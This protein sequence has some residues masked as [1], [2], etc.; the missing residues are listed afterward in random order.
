MNPSSDVNVN[1]CWNRIGVRGDRS[2]ERLAAHT[3]C[4]HCDKYPVAAGEVMQRALPPGYVKESTARYAEAVDTS[5]PLDCSA[6][7]FRIGQEW[8]AI[9]TACVVMVAESATPHRIPH[10][11][12][13]ELL[14]LVNIHGALYPCISLGPMLG[15]D[16]AVAEPAPATASSGRF[17]HM[18]VLRM[19]AQEYAVPVQEVRGIVRYHR[20][21]LETLPATARTTAHEDFQ[22]ILQDGG[23][24]VACL[25]AA[26]LA[27][28]FESVLK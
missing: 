26:R 28:R 2:C 7:A 12:R 25:D 19:A 15:V 3:H 9:P 22:G 20:A 5:V 18:L 4:H 1:D 6:L 17:S 13:P 16:D 24:R 23:R 10:R 27:S 21:M 11:Q 14:G 8:F